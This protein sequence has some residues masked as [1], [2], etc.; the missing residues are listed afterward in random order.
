MQLKRKNLEPILWHL[1]E[2]FSCEAKLLCVGK[3]FSYK[4]ACPACIIIALYTERT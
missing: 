2:I 4:N 3:N 1:E